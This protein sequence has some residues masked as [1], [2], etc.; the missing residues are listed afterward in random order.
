M[1]Q[2]LNNIAGLKK[3]H[4]AQL[5]HTRKATAQYMLKALNAAVIHLC[6]EC[7][8]QGM[9]DSFGEE[10]KLLSTEL[11]TLAG[12]KANPECWYSYIAR[13]SH[14]LGHVLDDQKIKVV[15]MLCNECD[16]KSK[17]KAAVQ[18]AQMDVE[19]KDAT[20]TVEELVS[21]KVEIE[22]T[23][24]TPFN[25]SDLM[26]STYFSLISEEIQASRSSESE[27]DQTQWFAPCKE[28]EAG[29]QAFHFQHQCRSL[30]IEIS[31]DEGRVKDRQ[32]GRKEQAVKRK[33][34]RNRRQQG[35]RHHQKEG[36]GEGDCWQWKRLQLE[37]L[38]SSSSLVQTQCHVL[39]WV[40]PP[41][42]TFHCKDPEMYP[43][44]FFLASSSLQHRF[45]VAR[46]SC[47]YYDTQITNSLFHNLTDVTLT[48]E[49]MKILALNYKFVPKPFKT[50]V[51]SAL[52]SFDD[53]ARRLC[54]SEAAK[55]RRYLAIS[56]G[57][58]PD[59][60]KGQPAYIPK[61]H[62]PA[63][64]AEAEPLILHVECALS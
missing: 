34:K 27:D 17:K 18:T 51:A 8:V 22:S 35:Q 50:M 33:R 32:E 4:E 23:S 58:N 19:M 30:V 41:D 42:V 39:S 24:L 60:E 40:C 25:C 16:A 44:L 43:S 26:Y 29:S 12:I 49:Q 3:G 62:I 1:P 2:W 31:E 6:E 21:E 5:A 38:S 64:E 37:A 61:F 56:R 36:E 48:Y 57:L 52:E 9:V 54:L 53:F 11:L 46:M 7:E 10:L 20:K 14:C 15:V 28:A 55:R 63:F 47:L 13:V 45:V 59:L